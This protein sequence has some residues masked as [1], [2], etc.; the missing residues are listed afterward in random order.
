MSTRRNIAKAISSVNALGRCLCPPRP[1]L[2]ILMYHAIGSPALGDSLGLFSVSPD[3]FAE[4]M[5]C[6]S[7]RHSD[8][9]VSLDADVCIASGC[10]VAITFDDGYQDNLD[11]AA[12]ILV[13]NKLPF[14]VFVTSDFVRNKRPGFLSPASLREL[15]KLP[16]ATIGAHGASHVALTDCDDKALAA[17][18]A[19]SRSYLEDLLGVAVETMAYP[20]GAANRRV[21]DAAENAGY[22]LA[23]CS[24]SNTNDDARDRMLLGRTEVLAGDSARVFRQKLHG[25]WDWYRWRTQDPARS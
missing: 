7:N 3:E 8:Q 19:G 11:V 14:S 5:E 22:R 21:R 4:H 15:A 2:R 13:K 20:Y 16:G 18:L 24:F 10:R 9:M 25:D 1:G 23:A 12:P 17:E 6:L